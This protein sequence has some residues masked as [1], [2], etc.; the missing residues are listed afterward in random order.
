M[1]TTISQVNE[2]FFKLFFGLSVT[3]RGEQIVVPCRYARKSA[4]DYSEEEENQTYP[5]IALQ[6]HTP[7]LKSE[8]FVDMKTYLGGVDM[9]GLKSYLFYRP[10]WMEFIFD[11]SIAATSYLDF[12]GLKDL[13]SRNF[14]HKEHLLFNQRLTGED[15]VGDVIP[16]RVRTT[17]IP[18]TDGVMEVNYE[19]TLSVWVYTR[20]GQEKENVQFVINAMDQILEPGVFTPQFDESFN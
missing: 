9:E 16:F 7:T 10:L 12:V 20:E 11:V 17:D 3:K 5:V 1:I 13:M 6:D 19:F 18:R 15:A 2:E 14:I 4:I 8:W